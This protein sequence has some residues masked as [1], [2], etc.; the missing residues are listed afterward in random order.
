MA[1][2]AALKTYANFHAYLTEDTTTTDAGGTKVKVSTDDAAV[3]QSWVQ[4][5]DASS[6]RLLVGNFATYDSQYYAFETA[7]VSSIDTGTGIITFTG[8]LSG[9]ANYTTAKNTR[10]S[11]SLNVDGDCEFSG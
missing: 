11:V 2:I 4:N 5:F 6:C 7:L 3:L 10:V 8:A 9:K 1:Q